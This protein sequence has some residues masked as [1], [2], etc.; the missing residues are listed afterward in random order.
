MAIVLS[1]SGELSATALGVTL[2]HEHLVVGRYK[3]PPEWFSKDRALALERATR[4]LEQLR[5]V[6]V[7]TLIDPSPVDLG[8]DV[9]LIAEA[10]KRSGIQVICATGLYT[11]ESGF[12]TGFLTMS[13]DDL[14]EHFLRELTE[15]ADA[16]GVRPG[17]IKCATGASRITSAEERALRAAAR[18]SKRSGTPII[19]HTSAGT[20][21]PEQADLFLDEGLDPAA[22]VIGHCDGSADLEYHRRV[23]AK[24]CFLGIDQVGNDG[25]TTDAQ[26]FEILVSLISEGFAA[27]IMLS[28][29]RAAWIVPRSSNLEAAPMSQ[30]QR[31]K[32][33]SGFTYLHRHFLPKLQDRG[34]SAEQIDMMLHQNPR[35]LFETAAAQSK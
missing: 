26:R 20:M 2:F 9:M 32:Y 4:Q 29:D 30:E 3:M 31:E 7:D 27:Q 12:P 15:G 17:V 16:S 22:A 14:A 33:R 28:Q 18:A 8:R 5:D 10:A 35:R 6:G 21:G 19:T 23:L 34:V 1:T 11:E 13:A 25:S 24:G